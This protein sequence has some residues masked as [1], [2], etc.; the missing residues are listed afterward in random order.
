MVLMPEITDQVAGVGHIR[1]IS[2]G[3][4]TDV[5]AALEGWRPSP[6]LI[7]E[8]PSR[9]VFQ[10]CKLAFEPLDRNLVCYS[11]EHG[12]GIVLHYIA[13]QYAESRECAWQCGNNHPRNTQRLCQFASVQPPSTT[14][15]DQ[16]ELA[17][18]I[19]TL[20]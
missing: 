4:I 8:I 7:A 9:A 13:D 5:H 16:D 3:L 12:A 14:E 15:G 10:V 1:F 11:P 17:R 18:V 20:D 19:A 2:L 6:A